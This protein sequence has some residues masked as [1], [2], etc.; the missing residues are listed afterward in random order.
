MPIGRRTQRSQELA[1]EN[2]HTGLQPCKG[3]S[4][5]FFSRV[6]RGGWGERMSAEAEGYR[7]SVLEQILGC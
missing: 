5:A 6:Q 7:I 2:M 3:F 1:S 4:K